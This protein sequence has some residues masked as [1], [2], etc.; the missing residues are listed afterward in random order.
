[1][2]K[3]ESKP[4]EATLQ[5]YEESIREAPGVTATLTRRRYSKVRSKYLPM[6]RQ[7]PDAPKYP[8]RWKSKKQRNYVMAMLTEED[9]LPYARTHSLS[10]AWEMD[11]ST[12]QDGGSITVYNDNPAADYVQG[13]YAQPFHLDT[14]WPQAAPI[15]VEMEE[16]LNEGLVEDFYTATDPYAGIPR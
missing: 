4:D 3:L 10:Q 1:L 5:L 11:I 12:R 13:D 14:G 8:L 15:F 16:E 6:F 2:Y 7:E 9:N